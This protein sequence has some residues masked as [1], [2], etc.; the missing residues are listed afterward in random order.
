M[1]QRRWEGVVACVEWIGGFGAIELSINGLAVAG[2]DVVAGEVGGS[3][4]AGV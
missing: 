1:R 2:S 4:V 3:V